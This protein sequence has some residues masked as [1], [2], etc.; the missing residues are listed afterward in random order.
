M[1]KNDLRTGQAL[2]TL[3]FI[4]IIAVTITSAACVVILINSMSGTKELQGLIAFQVAES[5][6]ETALLRVLR[7]PGYTG[8]T[9]T[10]ANGTATINISGTGTGINPYIITSQGRNG[11]FLRTVRVTATY[12]NNLLTANGAQEI[13]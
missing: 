4:V 5:G 3:L 1:S 9:L 7:N 6:V 11:K 8:E 10:M 13:F 12:V 2:I